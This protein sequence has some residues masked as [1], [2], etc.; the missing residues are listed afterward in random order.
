MKL[1]RSMLFVPGNNPGIIRDV[2]IYKPD[3]VMFDLE[4]A[5]AITEKDSA[6]FLV[7]NMLKNLGDY[8]KELGI[9]TVV[10][11]NG[12]ATEFWKD[13]IKAVVTGGVEVVRIPMTESVEDVMAVDAEIEKVER[14][15]NMEV[16]STK[17]MVAVETAL[18]VMNS[19]AIA[20]SPTKRLIG[21]ALSGE[22]F[23]TSMKTTRTPEG[24]E[25]YVARG[26]I[27]MA[28][29]ACGLEVLDTVYA[30]VNNDE[31]FLKEANLIKRMGFG[32]K[33]LIHPRQVELIHDVY[34]PTE[35]EI[36][37]AR[38][39][40]DATEE[41]L[42]QNLGVFTVDGKMVDKPIIERAQRVLQLA[43]AAGVLVGGDK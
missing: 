26:M 19:F 24:D 22:D 32:G 6:R 28:G 23:V 31:G 41:A 36:S 13:D 21:M 7:H 16:G 40:V 43:E 30:D 18:G 33:S 12:L 4:D 11:I 37:K 20:K 5:I 25:L 2:H 17:I 1:R 15:A 14:E 38:K 8:Y 10:R 3:S 42:K 9:E 27:A 34:T 29:R 39:I 35:V